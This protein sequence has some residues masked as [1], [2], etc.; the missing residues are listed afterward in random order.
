MNNLLAAFA[1][2]TVFANILLLL[3]FLAGFLATTSMVRESFPEFSIDMISISVVYPGADPAEVEE[4]INQKIEDAL[5]S[6]QGIDR[7]TTKSYENR[8]TVTVEVKDG[9]DTAD[10]LNDVES[11]VN[12]ISTFPAG[13]EKP[14]IREIVKKQVVMLLA[15]SGDLSEKQLKQWGERIKDEVKLIPLISQV[16]AYGTRAYEIGI[17]ISEEKL[18]RYGLTFEQ[19]AASVRKSS[20][21]LAGGTLRTV[22]EEIRSE[23]RRVG[24]E[25]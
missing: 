21:N 1:R 14:V 5:E 7:Y 23:E 20:F 6:V 10:V 8:A 24:K 2:N 22:G 3:I 11:Q 19:V 9:Y 16:E 12:A 15:L 4:G 17:E 13:A 18:R 25:C